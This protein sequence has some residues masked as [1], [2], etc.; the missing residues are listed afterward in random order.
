MHVHNLVCLYLRAEQSNFICFSDFVISSLA[1]CI[2]TLYSVSFSLLV[3]VAIFE[4]N[5]LGSE[6]NLAFQNV[7]FFMLQ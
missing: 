4:C 1:A 6:L 2:E 3:K 5:I 7:H